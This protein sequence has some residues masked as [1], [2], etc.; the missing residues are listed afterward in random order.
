MISFRNSSAV[1]SPSALSLASSRRSSIGQ[2]DHL[3]PFINRDPFGGS[4]CSI[5]P[6]PHEK[7]PYAIRNYSSLPRNF[8]LKQSQQPPNNLETKL[9]PIDDN[10]TT[11]ENVCL[12]KVIVPPVSSPRLGSGSDG[13]QRKYRRSQKHPISQ[14]EKTADCPSEGCANNHKSFNL[15]FSVLVEC[16]RC[17]S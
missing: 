17:N 6:P 16:W 11:H 7:S 5:V 14:L 8:S 10:E 12:P 3:S 9:P 15:N 4:G 2:D 13:I 1:T